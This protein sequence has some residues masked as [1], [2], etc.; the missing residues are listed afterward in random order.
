ML[1]VLN[2]TNCYDNKNIIPNAVKI[3]DI[4]FF[5]NHFLLVPLVFCDVC[6]EVD[7]SDDANTHFLLYH[8]VIHVCNEQLYH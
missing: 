5:F 8:T 4:L 7:L 1:D 2:F 3:Y 6:Q